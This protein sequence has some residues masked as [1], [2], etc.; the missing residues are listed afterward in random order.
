MHSV[1]DS[2]GNAFRGAVRGRDFNCGNELAR[3]C[4]DCDDVGK[5][6]TDIDA[7][8]AALARGMGDIF[9]C[10]LINAEDRPRKSSPQ[11]TQR[12]TEEKQSL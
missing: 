7:D 6:S 3:G 12:R 2:G 9:L 8:A 5:G 1:D 4:I 10:G 11:R